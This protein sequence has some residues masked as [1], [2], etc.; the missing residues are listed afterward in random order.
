MFRHTQVRVQVPS[1]GFGLRLIQASPVRLEY[2]QTRVH[3]NLHTANW[4]RT[5]INVNRVL[6]FVRT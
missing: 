3:W 6:C 1:K 5:H 2:M 4:T